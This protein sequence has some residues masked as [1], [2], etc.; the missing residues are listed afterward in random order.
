LGG[1]VWLRE[2]NS[3]IG[4]LTE[5][6]HKE[7]KRMLLHFSELLMTTHLL[8]ISGRQEDNNRLPG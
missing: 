7:A 3:L 4:N 6:Y 2:Q 1:K 5:P 8:A